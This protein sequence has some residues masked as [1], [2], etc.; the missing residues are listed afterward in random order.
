[1]CTPY[2]KLCP[3][4]R[5]TLT[6]E[7]TSNHRQFPSSQLMIRWDTQVPW[8]H[9]KWSPIGCPGTSGSQPLVGL[10]MVNAY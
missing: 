4:S 5:S 9:G 7:L 1:M 2:A 6:T 3:V 10:K 8:Q